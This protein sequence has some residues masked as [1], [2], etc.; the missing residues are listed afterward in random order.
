MNK[1]FIKAMD[2]YLP[3]RVLTNEELVKDFSE[4]SVDKIIEKGCWSEKK[5]LFFLNDRTIASK[6]ADNGQLKIKE[7]HGFYYI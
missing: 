5:F 2:Y 1:A 6:I 4:W 3:K 7:N